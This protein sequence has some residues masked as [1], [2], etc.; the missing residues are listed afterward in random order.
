MN[1]S[2]TT[3]KDNVDTNVSTRRLGEFVWSRKT[4]SRVLTLFPNNYST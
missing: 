4:N 1:N 2:I 3:Y